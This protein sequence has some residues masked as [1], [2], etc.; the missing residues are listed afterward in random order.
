MVA[1]VMQGVVVSDKG[2]KTV[3]VE[4]ERRVKHPLYKKFIRRR[5]RFH[6]HDESNRH[7]VGDSVR[8]RECRPISKTKS[9]QVV[10]EG[11]Q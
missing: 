11:S 4:V 6:A 3:V 5:K 8:I 2:D 9:W 7:A 1:R 10:S